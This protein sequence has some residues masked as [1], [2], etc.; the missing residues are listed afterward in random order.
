MTSIVR[1]ARGV[2]MA[3][4]LLR[5]K[6]RLIF[7]RS[8]SSFWVEARAGPGAAATPVERMRYHWR[9]L[10]SWAVG[11]PAWSIVTHAETLVAPS[12][13][14]LRARADEGR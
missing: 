5:S 2:L 4:R 12:P 6:R 11:I 3:E 1:V 8:L 13:C 10:V 14:M 7:L 9:P